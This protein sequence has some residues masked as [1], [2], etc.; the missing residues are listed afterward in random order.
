MTILGACIRTPARGNTPPFLKEVEDIPLPG[1]STRFDYQSLDATTGLLYLSHMGDGEVVVFDTNRNK[2]ITSVPGFPVV[3]GVLA[4]PS[5]KAVYASVTR[6]HE[7][8]VL[9]TETLKVAK[10]MPAGRFPDGIAFAPEVHKIFVSDESGGVETVID[11]KAN[12]RTATI[13]MGGE[14]G[15][16]QYDPKS[17]HIFACVQT[18]NEL[19]EIDPETDKIEALYPLPGSRHPHGLYIDAENARAYIACEGNSKLLTFDLKSHQVKQSF[20][21][22]DDPD[23]LAFDPG[24][25]ILYVACESGSVSIFKVVTPDALQSLGTFDIGPNSHSVSVDPKTHRVFFPLKNVNGH[26]V[27]RIMSPVSH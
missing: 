2:V 13:P 9:D 1:G 21:V 11:T 14:V 4:V 23:V 7:I 17:H 27:L 16:T 6:N 12:V 22:G 19:V 5:L 8:A 10:R 20:A 15:N 26:P 25:K 3:T 24:G 18:E